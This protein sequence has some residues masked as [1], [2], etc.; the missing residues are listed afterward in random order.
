ME[1]FNS[2]KYLTFSSQTDAARQAEIAERDKA[3]NNQKDI[4]LYGLALLGTVT[5]YFFGRVPAELHAVQAQKSANVAQDMA[6]EAKDAENKA[7]RDKTRIVDKT[8]LSVNQALSLAP[9]AHNVAREVPGEGQAAEN[10]ATARQDLESLRD[11]L[12][13]F[14]E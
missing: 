3:F 1:T 8:M 5:G 14:Q 6:K 9:F 10:V 2:A 11:W 13:G 4:L 12:H 7:K